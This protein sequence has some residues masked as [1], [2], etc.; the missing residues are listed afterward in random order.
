MFNDRALHP[1]PNDFLNL[2]VKS[3]TSA[4]GIS[5]LTVYPNFALLH[6][7][8]SRC[9]VF[10]HGHYIESIY[11]LMTR[12]K[13]LFFPHE[14]DPHQIWDLEAEN[15]AWIDFFWSALGRSGE[16]GTDVELIY[17]KMQNKP[18]LDDVLEHLAK[19]L[20][21]MVPPKGSW[22]SSFKA[23]LM[24]FALKHLV[25][26]LAVRE[27]HRTDSALSRDA[28]MGLARY[29]E[30]FVMGEI[31]RI[32]NLLVPQNLTFVFGHT[33]KPFESAGR[34]KGYTKP[35]KLVNS[36][37]WVVDTQALSPLKGGAAIVVDEDLNVV[38]LRIYNE[39]D[40]QQQSPVHINAAEGENNPLLREL[41]S[42]INPKAESWRRLSEL[43]DRAI[44][45]H[46]QNHMFHILASD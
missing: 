34:F 36:G 46:R 32:P 18:A 12:L 42:L 8:E 16:V 45:A 2:A 11:S 30:Q 7:D 35:V 1:I 37:G 14:D 9:V 21:P 24:G 6:P 15:G 31:T 28:Q 17:D 19:S 23:R 3:L 39:H 20:A 13:E 38:S 43:A 29:V 4:K 5:F 33:H 44:I 22:A 41:S 40:P 10:H 25:D 26:S 27:V